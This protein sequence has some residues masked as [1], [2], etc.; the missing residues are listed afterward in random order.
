MVYNFRASDGLAL[1]CTILG[2]V[3][4]KFNDPFIWQS[5]GDALKYARGLPS[6]GLGSYRAPIRLLFK[7]KAH[8]STSF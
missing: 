4:E 7:F 3:H 1:P 5:V 2:L 8:L 6:S